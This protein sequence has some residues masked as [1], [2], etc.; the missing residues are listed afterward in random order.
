MNVRQTI[1]RAR[2]LRE[3]ARLARANAEQA[4]AVAQQMWARAQ[5]ALAATRVARRGP[6][7]T[8]QALSRPPWDREGIA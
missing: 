1:E 4:A 6:H 7:T 3:Q 5:D 2:M 8:T